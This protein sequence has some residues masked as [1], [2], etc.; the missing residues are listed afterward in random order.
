VGHRPTRSEQR[1]QERS[2]ALS[3]DWAA[4][5]TE[6][7]P[8]PQRVVAVAH[9]NQVPASGKLAQEL[10]EALTREGS[11]VAALVTVDNPALAAETEAVFARMMESGVRQAKLLR[12]PPRDPRASLEHAVAELGSGVDWVVAWGNVL[13][14]LFQPYFTIV[15][16]GHR[17]ELTSTGP[18]VMQAQLEVTSPG[19]ELATLLARKLTGKAD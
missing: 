18:L 2:R 7:P 11:Q 9:V 5:P 15:V 16:T 13:P 14:Q 3:Q 17:R 8:L 12:K 19:P 1:E 10:C 6:R 4:R